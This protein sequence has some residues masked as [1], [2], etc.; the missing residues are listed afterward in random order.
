LM[1]DPPRG[2]R[3]GSTTLKPTSWK[4][5][6]KYLFTNKSFMLS[7][8]GFTCVTFVTGALAWWGP[9]Y[10][11]YGLRLQKEATLTEQS[12][13]SFYFGV[14]TAVSGIIGVPLGAFAA[15]KLRAA[16]LRADPLICAVGLLVSTPLIFGGAFLARFH[17]T[18]CFVL[19]FFGE[20]F[21]N[22]NWSIVA[23]ILLYVVIP[24]RRSSAEAFQILLSHALGDAGSPYLVGLLAD[25]I[26]P[27]ISKD[28]IENS[29]ALIIPEKNI[30]RGDAYVEFQSLQYS[31]Y[32]TVIIQILGGVCF[33]VTAMYI[34]NDK[35]NCDGII[36]QSSGES[37]TENSG[38]GGDVADDSTIVSE[39]L[40]KSET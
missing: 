14:I 24:T 2:E 18:A 21:L 7:T 6:M 34:V 13:V 37:I 40:S 17:E 35:R 31:L 23:D 5:D 4:E 26:K 20:V 33:L 38:G 27:M 29:T 25:S 28:G 10:I 3:E 12:Q 11:Y 22:L 36:A 8:M 30:T 1:V 16:N 9:T 39:S 19:I 15:T 32:T